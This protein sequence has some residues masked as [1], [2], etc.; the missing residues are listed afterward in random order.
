MLFLCD[1]KTEK[2][3]AY[4]AFFLIKKQDILPFLLLKEKEFTH[5]LLL[6]NRH[7]SYRCIFFLYRLKKK[8]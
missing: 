1:K 7:L 2:I 5:Y 4:S 6:I 8:L 3:D